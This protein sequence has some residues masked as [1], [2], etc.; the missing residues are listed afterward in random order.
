MDF[1][2]VLSNAHFKVYSHITKMSHLLC[3]KFS[4]GTH[5][6]VAKINIYEPRGLYYKTAVVA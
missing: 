5:F 6:N 1:L 3:F 4:F 2:S